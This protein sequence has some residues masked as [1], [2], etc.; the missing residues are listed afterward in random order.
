[1]TVPK[2]G[3]NTPWGL[4]DYVTQ[5]AEGIWSV[6]TPGHGGFILDDAHAELIPESIKPVTGDNHYWEEDFDYIVP[7]LFFKPEIE[8]NLE[9]TDFSGWDTAEEI[10]KKERP[11]WWCAIAKQII[12]PTEQRS[13]T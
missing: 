12:K 5:L 13:E 9:H 10:L 8:P 1:M 7:L 3:T 4:I 2:V 6:S 11:E